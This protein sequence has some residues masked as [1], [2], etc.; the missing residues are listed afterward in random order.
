LHGPF[1]DGSSFAD[2]GYTPEIHR[3]L[4]AKVGKYDRTNSRMQT[5]IAKYQLLLCDDDEEEIC[6]YVGRYLNERSETLAAAFKKHAELHASV[7]FNTCCGANKAMQ[8]KTCRK[9]LFKDV[10]SIFKV[11][12]KHVT[13]EAVENEIHK[14]AESLDI[15]HIVPLAASVT[16][17]LHSAGMAHLQD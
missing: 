13:P 11:V 2:A 14:V 3:K 12:M 1:A 4:S 7:N 8:G 17:L 6:S 16:V 15:E 5:A 10:G 9:C